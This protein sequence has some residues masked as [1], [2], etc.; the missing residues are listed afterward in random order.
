MKLPGK[1]TESGLSR[2]SHLAFTQSLSGEKSALFPHIEEGK[3][4][5]EGKDKG[6]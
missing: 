2:T 3:E 1:D 4:E 6:K 5:R